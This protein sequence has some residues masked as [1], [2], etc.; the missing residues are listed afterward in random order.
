MHNPDLTLHVH[1]TIDALHLHE[2]S[3]LRVERDTVAKKQF[4]APY[5]ARNADGKTR[6]KRRFANAKKLN[7]RVINEPLIGDHRPVSRS[8][9]NAGDVARKV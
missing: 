2:N 5:R 4:L 6:R 3:L 9:G 8:G 1:G 7:T